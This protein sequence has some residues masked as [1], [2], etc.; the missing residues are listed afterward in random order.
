MANTSR[1]P[2]INLT[3]EQKQDLERISRSRTASTRE[4]ERAGIIPRYA[5]R[6]N[7]KSIENTEEVKAWV[8]N[9]ACTKP[10]E[11]GCAAEVWS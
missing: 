9:L 1:S 2:S 10:N 11:F 5:A 3:E 6:E 8:V 7:I 4:V